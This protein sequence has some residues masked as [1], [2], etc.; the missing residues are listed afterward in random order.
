MTKYL[1][2][3]TNEIINVHPWSRNKKMYEANPDRYARLFEE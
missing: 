1:D 2:T 3:E